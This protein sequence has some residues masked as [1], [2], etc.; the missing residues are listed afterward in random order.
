MIGEILHMHCRD[1]ILTDK[2]HIDIDVLNPIGRIHGTDWCVDM[3]SR[4]QSTKYTLNT[5]P[6]R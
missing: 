5:W 4:F 2:G 6:V 3:K 1:D